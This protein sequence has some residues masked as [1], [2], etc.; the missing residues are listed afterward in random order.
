MIREYQAEAKETVE[1]SAYKTTCTRTCQQAVRCDDS[2]VSS[3]NKQT[4]YE[5]GRGVPRACSGG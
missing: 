1:H 3:N 2:L 5:R 4:T